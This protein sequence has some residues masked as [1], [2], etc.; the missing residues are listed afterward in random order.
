[1]RK[2]LSF[3]VVSVVIYF[4]TL[5]LTTLLTSGSNYQIAG[6]FAIISGLMFLFFPLETLQFFGFFPKLPVFF[7]LI[8]VWITFGISIIC[9]CIL[10]IILPIAIGYLVIRSF[11]LP[12][13]CYMIGV[14]VYITI[15]IALNKKYIYLIS[16]TWKGGVKFL[17]STTKPITELVNE[18]DNIIMH[19]YEWVRTHK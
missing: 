16:S 13:F 4:I 9:V 8:A 5:G 2:A 6:I 7:L 15:W 19:V 11:G 14:M 17:E 10:E 12:A 1:M 18:I 3:L